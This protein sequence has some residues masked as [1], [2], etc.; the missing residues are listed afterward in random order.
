M[1]LLLLLYLLMPC[2][3]TP[4]EMENNTKII[5]VTTGTQWLELD[6][7]AN[8]I[9]WDSFLT[10]NKTMY[11]GKTYTYGERHTLDNAYS[12]DQLLR[13]HTDSYGRHINIEKVQMID[14]GIYSCVHNGLILNTINVVVIREEIY[15]KV[16]EPPHYAF[17]DHLVT[18]SYDKTK[19]DNLYSNYG[20]YV[21]FDYMISYNSL[22]IPTC[23][24]YK[25]ELVKNITNN[26]DLTIYHTPVDKGLYFT[27][28]IKPTIGL[29]CVT[30][31]TNDLQITKVITW[32]SIYT[33]K[34]V[35]PK[36]STDSYLNENDIVLIIFLGFM[37]NVIMFFGTVFLYWRVVYKNN[38]FHSWVE[39]KVHTE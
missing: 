22:S 14:A 30:N 33:D 16:R 7:N 9:P 25:N 31:V 28:W 15:H 6:C 32:D 24:V 26:D 8:H 18:H 34:Y 38:R 11:D 35:R 20:I 10:W 39:Y 37:I 27:V 4:I 23:H 19:F 29:S 13:Y 12:C 3:G 17:L 5:V 36:I 1:S 2:I 21:I